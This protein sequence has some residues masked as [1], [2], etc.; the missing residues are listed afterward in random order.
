M[1]PEEKIATLELALRYLG[2]LKLSAA[3]FD[4]T[5]EVENINSTENGLLAMQMDI[6]RNPGPGAGP[7]DDDDDEPHVLTPTEVTTRLIEIPADDMWEKAMRVG[8]VVSDM[9]KQ[10]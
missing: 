2:Q 10:P 4:S 3:M 5:E 9:S 6:T 8:T 7:D 1:T